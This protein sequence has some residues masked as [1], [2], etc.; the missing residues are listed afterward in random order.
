MKKFFEAR[1]KVFQ[2]KN[3]THAGFTLIEL[4]IALLIASLTLGGYIAANILVQQNNEEMNERTIALQDANR[5]IE[6]IRAAARPTTPVF[7][8]NVTGAYPDNSTVQ[9]SGNLADEIIRINYEDLTANPLLLTATVTWTS[10]TRH[11]R[12]ATVQTYITQR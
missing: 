11:T 2:K 9:G 1:K 10:S 4:M 3:H 7:P 6:Q 8:E 12:T 5:A